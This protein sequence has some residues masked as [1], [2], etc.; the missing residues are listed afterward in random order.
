[1]TARFL[2]CNL[3]PSLLAGALAWWVVRFLIRTLRLRESR[4]RLALYGIPLLK[5]ALVL[6]GIG[7][8]LPWPSFF[9]GWKAAA[10]PWH[11]AVPLALIWAGV[12]LIAQDVARRSVYR[13]IL[14]EAEPAERVAPEV[15][16]LLQ[17]VCAR[18]REEAPWARR[19]PAP[20]VADPRRIPARLDAILSPRV[21]APMVLTTPGREAVILPDDLVRRLS[22]EELSG[23]LAHEVA[24]LMIERPGLLSPTWWSLLTPLS[25][26]ALAIDHEIRREAEKACDAAASALVKDPATYAEALVKCYRFARSERPARAVPAFVSQLTGEQP[27]ISE[28]V[29]E[30]L[31]ERSLSDAAWV[32]SAAGLVSWVSAWM[33]LF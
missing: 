17:E 32:Q 22:R 4:L 16:R 12:C 5:S 11:T 6:L 31:R 19:L 27:L 7:V 18:Y 33:L 20:F 26:I 29:E 23:V 28:R 24:H 21:H 14:A 8:V 10:V 25:P 30:L 2:F 9:D 3:L 13:E 15:Q 1:M